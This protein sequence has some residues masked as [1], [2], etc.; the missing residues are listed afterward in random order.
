[1]KGG[2]L[3]FLREFFSS[4]GSSSKNKEKQEQKIDTEQYVAAFYTLESNYGAQ[5]I[6]D[7]LER[8]YGKKIRFVSLTS[9]SQFNPQQY[10]DEYNFVLYSGTGGRVTNI[11][12]DILPQFYLPPSFLFKKTPETQKVM[13]IRD[14]SFELLDG[15]RGELSL[16]DLETKRQRLERAELA[17]LKEASPRGKHH[18]FEHHNLKDLIWILLDP[19]TKASY[20]SVDVL[21]RLVD[22]IPGINC[23]AFVRVK[24]DEEL[25]REAA[26]RA[27]QRE[28]AKG[29][30]IS[31]PPLMLSSLQTMKS[32]AM[33]SSE[34]KEESPNISHSPKKRF[35]L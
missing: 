22:F 7:T 11:S 9:Y 8:L 23:E 5:R 1:M 31:V 29:Q 2:P 4:F 14:C 13:I 16:T 19:K 34:S 33:S 15:Y 32:T 28:I 24:I 27:R 21:R 25:M 35:G 12:Y 30:K 26:E 10:Q 17:I 20:F 6:H 3:N 18:Y